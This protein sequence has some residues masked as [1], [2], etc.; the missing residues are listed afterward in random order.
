MWN[1]PVAVGT[2]STP[3]PRVRPSACSRNACSTAAI[4]SARGSSSSTS[5]RDTTRIGTELPDAIS[6]LAGG[7]GVQALEQRHA[8]GQH[9]V[10]VGGSREQGP[11]RHVDAAGL[12]VRVLAVAKIRFVNELGQAGEPAVAKLGA[13]DQRLERAVLSLMAQLHAGGVEGYGV[14]RK[15]RRRGEDEDRLGIDEALDQPRG[16][17]AVHVGPWPG[18][19]ASSAKLGE[20][21]ARSGFRLGL[22]RTS[23]A[24]ADHLFE[25]PDL[26]ATG[27]VEE[28]DGPDSLVV[29]RQ[30][31]E[32]FLDLRTS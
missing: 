18:D 5:A 6:A 2:D 17:D 4:Q 20:I 27:G 32:L 30:T 22:F 9:L 7:G 29:F 13:L 31:G 1:P 26:G 14:V 12:L 8:L 11:D 16:R 15:L 3:G 25:T 21:E 28:I 19:P 23:G 10:I 24:H